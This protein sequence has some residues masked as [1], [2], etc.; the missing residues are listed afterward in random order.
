MRNPG[1]YGQIICD[2]AKTAKAFD[3]Y[4]RLIGMEHDS[5]SCKHCARVVFVR[6]GERPEDIGGLCKQC[7]GLVCPECVAQGRCD[8]LEAKLR[9]HE[10]RA[11]ARRS[12]G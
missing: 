10:Q 8:P 12:Y 1:G 5:Y 11:E 9:R 2:D 7:F 3:R 4:G 6:V